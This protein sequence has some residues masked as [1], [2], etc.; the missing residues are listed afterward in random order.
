MTTTTKKTTTR[1]KTT[2]TPRT[3]TQPVA[4]KIELDSNS[5]VHEIFSAIDSQRTKAKKIEI[6]QQYSAENHLKALLIWNFDESIQSA[7]PDGTV[8]YQPLTEEATG[9][10]GKTGMP[11]H[12][13]L[14]K[15]WTKL[16]NFVKGGNDGM[17]KLKK[18]TMFINILE[19]LHPQEAEI[20]CLVKDKKLQ[21][22]YKLTK[23]LT[24]EA[25]PDIQWGN[26]S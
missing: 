2:T 13:T 20:L 17:N 23:E 3:K 11:P 21:T 25:Y 7:L 18:E 24:Q 9:K 5:F 6:L 22:R 19:S 12:S 1:K 10:A 26:R 4:E 8:P 16:Y 15:E 14:R